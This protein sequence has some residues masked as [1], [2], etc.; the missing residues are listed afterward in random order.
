MY[1]EMNWKIFA[2]LVEFKAKAAS[3]F[4]FVIGMAY[5]WFHYRH[6]ELVNMFL[7]FV[8]MFLFNMAVDILDN[9]MDYHHATEVH[10]YREKTNIIGR[11]GLS[12]RLIRNL[13]IG[14]I[15]IAAVLG[16]YLTIRTNGIVLILGIISFSV[17]IFYSS[18]PKPL[19]GLPVGELLSGVTMGFLIPLIC[20]YVNVSHLVQF[21]FSFFGNIFL[22]SLPA[23]FA[24]A[25]LM[26]ANNTCDLEEDVLN[27][28]FTLV[29]Y[30]GKPAAIRLFQ[31]LA[32]LPFITTTF[33]VFLG[34]VPRLLLFLWVIVPIIWRNT[35]QYSQRQIKLETFPL[36]IKNLI[37]TVSVF[38][39][40]FVLGLFIY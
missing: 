8:A 20:V 36:A 1:T 34:V 37:L 6:I 35:K 2:E 30:I 12:L 31:L 5:A 10:D 18:G 14:F 40:L 32:I 22:M 11:E 13:I 25:N 21:S 28:R 29:Y 24:I 17:G 9:Y 33:S 15:G 38:S 39:V 3:V 23:V 7:F 4:P 27:K 26:L 16:L 19:S